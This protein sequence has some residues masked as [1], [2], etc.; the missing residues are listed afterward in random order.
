[1]SELSARDGSAG[2][3]TGG[4]ERESEP[5]FLDF[6]YLLRTQGL[7]VSLREWRDLLCALELGLSA[8]DLR[9]FHLVAR[10]TLVKHERHYDLFDQCFA[11]YFGDATA[12]PTF[13][14]ALEEWLQ[15]PRPLP[16][17]DEAQLAQL[18]RLDLDELRR[19]FEERLQEQKERHD[20]GSHWIGTGGTSPFGHGGRH[21]SGIRVGGQ[22]QNRSAIQILGDRRFAD[23]R[24]DRILDTR[25]LSA[26]LRKLRR[27]RRGERPSELDIDETISATARQAGDLEIVMR[28]PREDQL[29]LLLLMDVG[30]S[31]DPFARL[32]ERLFSAAANASHFKRFQAYY[33]HNCVYEA[34]YEHAS[35]RKPIPLE[36]IL[37][38]RPP[39]TRLLILGDACMAPYELFSAGGAISYFHRN[40][41]PG[42][43][44]L[45]RLAERFEGAAWLNPLPERY[46]RHQTIDAISDCFPM[47]PLSLDGL[48]D[49]IET[50]RV[51]GRKAPRRRRAR[52]DERQPYI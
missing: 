39:E 32:V 3:R 47:Y 52:E 46:W 28:A 24:S 51:L 25:Q 4:D 21:P 37:R 7:P 44:W 9:R 49:A 45:E 36:R 40:P 14:S 30:G 19:R 48:G 27:L 50:L 18:E 20:G 2:V 1:M 12:P 41:M 17:L 6:F 34:L 29:E 43:R 10:A 26:A 42:I 35:L 16:T 22:G 31:M 33:F 11:W 15:D 23:Y 8:A 5:L 13:V 38:E